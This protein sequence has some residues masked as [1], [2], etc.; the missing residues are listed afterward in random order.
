MDASTRA[1][2]YDLF[3]LIVAVFLL[4]L[5]LILMR[6]SPPQSPALI[7]TPF[8]SRPILVPASP[9]LSSQTATSV[10]TSS[11]TATPTSARTASATVTATPPPS[12]TETSTVE[13]TATQVAEIPVTACEA[14]TSRSR[15]QTGK[16][17]ILQRRLNFRSSPGIRDNWLHT[18]MPGTKVEVISGPVCLPYANGAYVWWQIKL[19]YGQIGWSAEAPQPGTYYFIEPSP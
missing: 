8:P 17:A 18:N 6:T 16:S 7:T 10:S 2:G 11:P 1:P 12:S 13:P 4:I 9:T 15:L 19:P 3:K 14:A 5:V